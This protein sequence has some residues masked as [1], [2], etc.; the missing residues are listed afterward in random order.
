MGLYDD[1]L[2]TFIHIRKDED[3]LRLLTLKPENFAEG[4]PDPLSPTLPNIIDKPPEELS[5]IQNKHI[6]KS[7][8]VDDLEPIKLC[9]L[10]IYPGRRTPE[11]NNYATADQEIHIDILCHVDYENGDFRSSRITDRLNDLL[12]NAKVKGVFG[13]LEYVGGN[14]ISGVPRNYVGYKCV[15]EFGSFRK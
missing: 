7:V 5:D 9:R 10:F 2:N 3:L 15:Y 11:R 13:K 14:I 4:I 1:I 12:V 8:K 6:M